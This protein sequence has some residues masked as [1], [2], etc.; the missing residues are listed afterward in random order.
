MPPISKKSGNITTIADEVAALHGLT[1]STVRPIAKSVFNTLVKQLFE[2]GR[3]NIPGFCT[4]KI[5][6]SIKSGSARTFTQLR[7]GKAIRD[8]NKAIMTNP[9]NLDFVNRLL[10]REE[11]NAFRRETSRL[12]EL[13]YQSSKKEKRLGYERERVAAAI[14]LA[15]GIDADVS[16]LPEELLIPPLLNS[17]R[18]P[19]HRTEV[20]D[21]IAI[22]GV[23]PLEKLFLPKHLREDS[24][25]A[26]PE[27]DRAPS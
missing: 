19:A 10:E 4:I 22:D 5:D 12:R 16:N 23:F 20:R 13:T 18:L 24:Q 11:G 27:D 9:D 2:Y 7:L 6:M 1:K 25:Q 3:V 8:R 14:K 17:P 26:P 15:T 21:L